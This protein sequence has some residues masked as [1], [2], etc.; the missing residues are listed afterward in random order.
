MLLACDIGNTNIKC[1]LFSGDSDVSEFSVLTSA[2]EVNKLIREKG[3]TELAVSSVVPEKLM[4]LKEQLPAS[5]SIT[6]IN[7]NSKFNLQLSYNTPSTLGIDRIC[8]CEGAYLLYK[9]SEH[10][11]AYDE[12]TII[13]TID[14]G[15]AVTI[16][17]VSYPGIF[18]G[19][20]ISPGLKLMNSALNS[21]TAQLPLA[22]IS[23]YESFIGKDTE[24][25]IASG[26]IN[27]AAGLI[28]RAIWLC[29]SEKGAEKIFVFI[30]GGNAPAILPYLDFRYTY[31]KALVLYGI[32]AIYNLNKYGINFSQA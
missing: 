18:E 12:K 11:A 15:T 23:K 3:V 14:L 10:A 4:H 7:H 19:G 22:D 9:K 29:K 28:E 6:E 5:V 13:I 31:E 8:S 20:I 30:T 32:N 21:G 2:G 1:G 24:Q 17:F 27:S 16:N 25:C 26:I